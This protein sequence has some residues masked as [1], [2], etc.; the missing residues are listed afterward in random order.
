MYLVFIPLY[1]LPLR[2]KVK[3]FRLFWT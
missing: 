3:D 1:F 2:N